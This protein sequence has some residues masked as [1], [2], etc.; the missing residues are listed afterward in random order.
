MNKCLLLGLV[1]LFF[2]HSI[3]GSVG[4]SGIAEERSSG[5][6][7]A[8]QYSDAFTTLREILDESEI[9]ESGKFELNFDCEET[10]Q[11]FLS[12]NRVSASLYIHPNDHY[13]IIFPSESRV[14]F[15]S[16]AHSRVGLLI[17]PKN[18]LTDSLWQID[19]A[20]AEFVNAHFFEYA[21]QQFRG[22]ESYLEEAR[23]RSPDADLF[24]MEVHSDSIYDVDVHSVKSAF[25]NFSNDISARYHQGCSNFVR[26]YL[27]YSLAELELMTLPSFDDYYTRHFADGPLQFSNTAYVRAF[28]AC[29][30][31]FLDK[32][33]DEFAPGW[34]D[35]FIPL[36]NSLDS[37]LTKGSKDLYAGIWILHV[38]NDKA[39]WSQAV[40]NN[41]PILEEI[42]VLFP[43]NPKMQAAIAGVK[44]QAS[45]ISAGRTV[46]SFR[47]TDGRSERWQLQDSEGGYK[48][49]L[50]FAHW[51]T[52]SVKETRLLERLSEKMKGLVKIYA[53]GC[54]ADFKT[55]KKFVS[56]SPNSSVEFLFAGCNPEV[57]DACGLKLIPDALFLDA[58]NKTLMPHAPLPSG[59][60][61]EY[62]KKITDEANK[63][64][65]TRK[66]W[67]D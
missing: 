9:D 2:S 60:L 22:P 40:N 24:K 43:A 8:Y 41:E 17:E 59:R 49:F 55:F 36:N 50:F 35:G 29:F 61:E 58:E 47:L 52:E 53:V 64:G 1:F 54:D 48:Y 15:R 67:K 56:A 44:R 27:R 62:F 19:T 51:N 46:P 23:K 12:I 21:Y 18:N 13:N 11:I 28:R 30:H 7:Y 14:E 10:K 5:T 32:R 39:L 20:I 25:Q 37:I 6:V 33:K 31:G 38:L 34:S 26:Q 45:F 65:K 4:I 66:T 63:P 3:V 57:D 16:F 42:T